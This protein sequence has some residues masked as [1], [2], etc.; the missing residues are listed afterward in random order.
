MLSFR[1]WPYA[2]H[3]KI[4][5]T[6]RNSGRLLTPE[7]QNLDV[8][9]TFCGRKYGRLGVIQNPVHSY[10]HFV[11]EIHCFEILYLLNMDETVDCSLM[12]ASL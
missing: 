3:S 7:S 8:L 6:S 9:S 11:S 10:S 5:R 2:R 4:G 12:N 1:Q